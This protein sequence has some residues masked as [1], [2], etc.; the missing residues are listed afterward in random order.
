MPDSQYTVPQFIDVEDKILGPLSVRQFLIL[1]VGILIDVALWRLM[2]L[3]PF[4]LTG[5]P[6]FAISVVFTFARIN[7]MPF[8]YFVL[9]LVQSFRKP[10][11]RVWDKTMTLAE[12]KKQML[13][14][15]PVA[16]VPVTRKTAPAGSRL[17]ELT[18][19][20][21]TGGAYKPEE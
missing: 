20:V 16:A 10:R 17:Q 15:P 1:L 19:L 18:L 7:G 11:L 6:L 12:V 14:P 2:R 8:H 21:N 13:A 4:L 9:N 5:I 3:V